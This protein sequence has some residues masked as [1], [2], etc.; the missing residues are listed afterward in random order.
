M[1]GAFKFQIFYDWIK[2]KNYNFENDPVTILGRSFN[3]SSVEVFELK[4][5][6]AGGYGGLDSASLAPAPAAVM[7]LTQSCSTAPWGFTVMNS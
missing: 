6:Q 1:W 4:G 7:I 5:G 3:S 2:N